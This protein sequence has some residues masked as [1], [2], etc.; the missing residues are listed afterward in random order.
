M[1]N[2]QSGQALPLAIAALAIG[3]LVV[4]PF[5]GY[6]GS[7]LIGSQVYGQAITQQSACDA[8][9]EHA[10]WSL[11]KGELAEQFTQAGDEVIYQLSESINNLTVSITVTA[12]AT[13]G[14]SAGDIADTIIDTLEFDNANGYEPSIINVYG[15][16]F[17]IAYRGTSGDGFLKTISINADGEIENSVINTLEFDNANGY[18]P[19][20]IYVSGNIYAI[21]YRGSANDGF[22][23]TVSIDASGYI[24]NSAIDTLEFDNS[25]G[26]E[27]SIINVSGNVYAIAYRGPGNDGFL[28]TV[29][30]DASGHIGNSAIDT[31]EFDNSNGYEPSIINV[32]GNI[33]AIA[34][35]G[36]GND[37]FL[38][39]VAIDASGHIGNSAIDTLEFDTSNGYEPSIINVYGDVFTI[40]YRGTSKGGYLKTVTID[41]NG[42]IGNSIIDANTFDSY[43]Y[44]PCIINISNE[45][46]GI[47]YRGSGNR[48]YLITMSIA[49]DGDIASSVTD[50]IVFDASSGYEP[51]IINTSSN[52]YGI[53]YRGPNNDG[54]VKTLGMEE[55]GGSAAYEIA[56]TAGDRTIRA[57]VTIDNG[58][59]TIASWQ[60]E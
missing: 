17:A 19:C 7:N 24:G 32:S 40:A 36:P 49:A 57:F 12:N 45:M 58:T 26:Y 4:A 21:A 2:G 44:E 13:G 20:I 22:L 46:F 6:A 9:V 10:I 39:T 60:I 1:M 31:L 43:C 8:G 23:K 34:Y 25:N 55:S 50:T 47:T 56:A 14:G 37:G 38:K 28:K 48:G 54:F 29:S 16:V 59:A 42:N 41:A 15:E 35:R 18:E 30:I 51:V 52:I 33:Y 27:P 3:A 53:A 5:L 11:T